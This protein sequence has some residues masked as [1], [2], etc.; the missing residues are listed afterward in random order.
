MSIFH[1]DGPA[2]RIR[3]HQSA[4]VAAD[5]NQRIRELKDKTHSPVW[6]IRWNAKFR[7]PFA[8]GRKRH[9]ERRAERAKQRLWGMVI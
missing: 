7:L 6:W 4:V 3:M 8:E 2:L 1:S 5:A 9:F